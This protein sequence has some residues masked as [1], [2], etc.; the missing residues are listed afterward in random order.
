MAKNIITNKEAERKIET[1]ENVLVI[2]ARP[3]DVYTEDSDQVQGAIHLTQTTAQEM[4]QDL[5]KNR[6][7]LIYT[8]KGEEDVS[9]KFANFLKDKGFTAYAIKGGF[10]DW[11]DSGLPIEPINASGTPL[12]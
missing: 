9:K 3:E 5:P 11:R 2:D 8:T 7:Y 12:L 10:E 1:G 6:E 4:F